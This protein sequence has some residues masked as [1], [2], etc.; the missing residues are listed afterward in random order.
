MSSL[1]A[2]L[3]AHG[4]FNSHDFAHARGVQ[5]ENY[6]YERPVPRGRVYRDHRIPPMISYSPAQPGRGYKPACWYV[7]QGNVPTDP[8][9]HYRDH[10]RKTFTVYGRAE[11]E[12]Q[13]EAAK[14][15]ASEHFGVAEWKREPY[16]S[17][18]PA[19]FVDGRLAQLREWLRTLAEADPSV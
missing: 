15:W 6:P 11:K 16:G 1:T 19:E 12:P 5:N 4:I 9:A 3:R 2:Q 13:L 17:W 7:W 18:M 8:A 14:A 10:G